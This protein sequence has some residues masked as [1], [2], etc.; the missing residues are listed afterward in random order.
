M[1]NIQK[2]QI[3]KMK[4]R[5][6]PVKDQCEKSDIGIIGAQIEQTEKVEE[7]KHSRENSRKY[8]MIKGCKFPD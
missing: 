3:G 7:K 5:R 8:P 2:E 1:K 4:S 6:E